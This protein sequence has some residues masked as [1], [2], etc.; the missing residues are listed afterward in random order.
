MNYVPTSFFTLLK[1]KDPQT[2]H[3]SDK[4]HKFFMGQN[5]LDYD[6]ITCGGTDDRVHFFMVVLFLKQKQVFIF[7]PSN[8]TTTINVIAKFLHL[9]FQHS[10]WLDSGN[11]YFKPS[12][13]CIFSEEE[14]K[15]DCV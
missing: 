10:R 5:M 1:S 8:V 3:C 13:E 4:M 14:K 15:M 2:M 9:L 11:K 6:G 7:D 12:K